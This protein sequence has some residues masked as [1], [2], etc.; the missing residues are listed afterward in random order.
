MKFKTEADIQ[1]GFHAAVKA[2]KE[3]VK[4]RIQSGELRGQAG[5]NILDTIPDELPPEEKFQASFAEQPRLL[6]LVRGGGASQ[7]FEPAE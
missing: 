5:P 1:K 4:A 2:Y 7:T 6:Y 3:G